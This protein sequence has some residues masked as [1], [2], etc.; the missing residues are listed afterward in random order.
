MVTLSSQSVMNCLPGSMHHF[1]LSLTFLVIRTKANILKITGVFIQCRYE[2]KATQLGFPL[3]AL[4]CL[5]FISCLKYLT[6][7]PAKSTQNNRRSLYHHESEINFFYLWI[8]V[9][10]LCWCHYQYWTYC[11]PDA[12]CNRLGSVYDYNYAIINS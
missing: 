2:E 6:S 12:L 1:M 5:S 9:D 11:G 3:R 7:V 10:K 4:F 8:H